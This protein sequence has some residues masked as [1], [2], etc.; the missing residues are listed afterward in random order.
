MPVQPGIYKHYGGGRYRVLFEAHDSTNGP[1][2][3]LSMVVYVS[4]TTGRINVRDALEFVG[5]VTLDGVSVPR[6]VHE[7]AT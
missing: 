5:D 6:F 1:R 7:D 3:G 2:E 4:L